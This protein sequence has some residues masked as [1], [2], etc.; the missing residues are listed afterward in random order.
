[1]TVFTLIGLCEPP[2]L[3]RLAEFNEWFIDQH[4]E[5]TTKCPIFISG[6]V[7]KLT[8]DHIDI[9]TPSDYLSIYE[10]EAESQKEAERILNEWQADPNAWEGRKNHTDTREKFGD[11]PLKILG[12][13]WYEPI[14]EYVGPAAKK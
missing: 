1:M 2:S 13:G 11:M 9:A 4:I 14:K 7:L 10:I 5:D 8:G 3:D 6:K 12:S